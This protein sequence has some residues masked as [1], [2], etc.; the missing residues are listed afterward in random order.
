MNIFTDTGILEYPSKFSCEYM[1]LN[2]YKQKVF[3]DMVF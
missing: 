2:S 1:K 3:S